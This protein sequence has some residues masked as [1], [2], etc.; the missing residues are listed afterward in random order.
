MNM[1][2]QAIC[3]L[4]PAFLIQVLLEIHNTHNYLAFFRDARDAIS[5][6]T[7]QRFQ[8]AFLDRRNHLHS[9]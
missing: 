7:F 8:Q 2:C 1:V 3:N 9:A 5:K 6:G 4:A